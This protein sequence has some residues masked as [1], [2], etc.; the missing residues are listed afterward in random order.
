MRG[1]IICFVRQ[2][3]NIVTRRPSS[4]LA[5]DLQYRVPG[6]T[7]Y[8]HAYANIEKPRVNCGDSIPLCRKQHWCVS[9]TPYDD[10]AAP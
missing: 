4:V 10:Y 6:R 9:R 5:V 8:R 2:L 3:L 7:R 1:V